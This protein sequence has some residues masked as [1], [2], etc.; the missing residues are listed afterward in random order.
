MH[1][2]DQSD[3]PEQEMCPVK[4]RMHAIFCAQTISYLQYCTI[5]AVDCDSAGIVVERQRPSCQS[6]LR[7]PREQWS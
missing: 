5:N 1:V 7:I 2:F 6:I 4:N 3:L